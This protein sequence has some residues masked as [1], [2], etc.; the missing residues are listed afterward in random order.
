[1]ILTSLGFSV[2]KFLVGT[3]STSEK[4][5]CSIQTEKQNFLPDPLQAGAGWEAGILVGAGSVAGLAIIAEVAHI[6]PLHYSNA[7][8]H[9]QCH[10]QQ[11]AN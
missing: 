4:P 9:L 3:N 1:M 10:L 8:H 6:L 2:Y 5:C 7:L 11:V